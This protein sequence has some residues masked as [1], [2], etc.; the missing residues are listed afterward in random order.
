MSADVLVMEPPQKK[1]VEP[2]APGHLIADF[3]VTCGQC[4]VTFPGICPYV[5]HFQEGACQ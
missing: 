5:D 2:P 1:A 4:G 3:A